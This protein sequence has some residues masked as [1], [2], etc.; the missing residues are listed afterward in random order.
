MQ[1]CEGQWPYTHYFGYMSIAGKVLSLIIVIQSTLI[2]RVFILLADIIKFTSGSQRMRWI[3]ISVFAMYFIYY[4]VL[5]LLAP[6]NLE[7]PLVSRILIGIYPDFNMSWYS[8]I[9]N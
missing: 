9:G 3:L 6:M 2:R 8:D 1:I 4:G 7:I 5:N